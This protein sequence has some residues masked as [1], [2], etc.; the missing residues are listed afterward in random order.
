MLTQLRAAMHKEL[1]SFWRDP[2]ARR[3]VLV[4]PFLQLFL[5]T[6]AASMDVRNVDIA[7][8]NQDGGRW[9]YEFIARVGASSFVGDIVTVSDPEKLAEMVSNREVL[10]GIQF[11]PNFSREITAQ[12]P[13][14]V[15][16]LIDGRRANEGQVAFS[17]ISEVAAE[18][19]AELAQPE[20]A[21][22]RPRAQV[23]HWFNPNLEYY[24]FLT[25]SVGATLSLIIPLMMTSL[26]IAREREL[27][28][29]DQLLV[30]P[31]NSA[32][33]IAAKIIPAL[34]SGVFV[35][36]V[37]PAVVVYGFNIPY[38]GNY[39]LHLASLFVFVLSVVGIGLTVSAFCQTQQQAI[40]GTFSGVV[41]IMLTSGF[42]TPVDNMP[43]WL[44]LLAQANP[45]KHF[46]IVIQGSFLKSMSAAEVW[47]N[48]WPL[49]LIAAVT[50]TAATLIV[51]QRLQ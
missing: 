28:T 46:M 39:L 26:S 50:L 36:A 34:A 16:L 37:I 30:S 22:N 10:M 40:L 8:A 7:I 44:Q 41:P 12:R 29:Y 25:P 19:G 2:T 31:L 38:M 33:I 23:R 20:M 5:Y 45:L 24:W 21:G 13:G 1:L 47:A 35:G 11:L 9:S 51:R 27:G 32:E 48:T 3:M 6:Y 18:L 15:Q 43:D 17:Y 42:V 49:I 14:T 4:M